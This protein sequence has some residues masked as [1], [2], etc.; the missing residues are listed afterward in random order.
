M[1]A[2]RTWFLWLALTALAVIACYYWFDRPISTLVHAELH[3][4][5]AEAELKQ[6]KLFERLTY[7]AEP[8]APL[9]AVAFILVGLRA[10]A[11]LPPRRWQAAALLCGISVL[12][13]EATKNQLKYAFG[14]TWPETWINNN[15]SF[16]HNNVFGFFPFH[17]GTGW[18]AFPSGHT[19]L[20]FAFVSVLWI[21]Y[22]RGRILYALAAAAVSI[23]LIGA[24][25][26]F[27]SD[28]IAG[29]F[30]GCSTG[31]MAVALWRARDGKPEERL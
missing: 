8:L 3:R 24:N 29:A 15:P 12:V 25:Y 9:S 2:I 17:G 23:G 26:H 21:L 16:I 6:F 30:L 22:P 5:L 20:I 7:L 10:L 31:W 14:R 27:L 28:V 19:T 18:A 11:G 4:F 1:N 13:A